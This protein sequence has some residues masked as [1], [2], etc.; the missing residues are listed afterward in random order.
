MGLMYVFTSTEMSD[1]LFDADACLKKK[2]FKLYFTQQTSMKMQ[3][4]GK[5]VRNGYEDL[6]VSADLAPGNLKFRARS[7]CVRLYNL[8][9]LP[10]GN[11]PRY[12][13]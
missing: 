3:I 7:R 10:V 1:S 4:N 11:S 12:P 2:G 13:L 6:W 9:S 8:D 5:I